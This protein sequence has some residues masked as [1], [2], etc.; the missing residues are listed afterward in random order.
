MPLWLR[1]VRRCTGRS[2][3]RPKRWNSSRSLCFAGRGGGV[4]HSSGRK[5]KPLPTVE[6]SG[7]PGSSVSRRW[8]QPIWQMQLA[9]SA[10]S[11]CWQRSMLPEAR[12]L[13][14]YS[15]RLR[16][17]IWYALQRVGTKVGVCQQSLVGRQNC[18]VLAT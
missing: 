5:N 11:T 18:P 3:S 10:R 14:D 17:S 15:H 1:D 2:T 7:S 6:E 9:T 4:R 12:R 16:G 8:L 13:P